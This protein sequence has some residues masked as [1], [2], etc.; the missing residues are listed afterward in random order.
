MLTLRLQ[1]TLPLPRLVLA[2]AGLRWSGSGKSAVVLELATLV[3]EDGISGS[4]HPTLAYSSFGEHVRPVP[5]ALQ[6]KA[7]CVSR[8]LSW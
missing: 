6:K 1:W 7:L 4:W 8:Y 3:H 5:Q 2:L